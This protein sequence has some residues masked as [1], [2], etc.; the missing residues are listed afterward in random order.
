ML[1]F[2]IRPLTVVSFFTGKTATRNAKVLAYVSTEQVPDRHVSVLIVTFCLPCTWTAAH[3][4]SQGREEGGTQ[5]VE[6][7]GCY[8]IRCDSY[9]YA[10][11]HSISSDYSSNLDS[12]FNHY[13][14]YDLDL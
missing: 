12:A 4:D 2:Y 7:S 14:M 11:A 5:R 13:N 10:F 9:C 1:I 8:D 6:E 3:A